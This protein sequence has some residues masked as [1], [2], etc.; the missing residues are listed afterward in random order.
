MIT[1]F[2]ALALWASLYLAVGRGIVIAIDA[3]VAGGLYTRF[4]AKRADI[5]DVGRLVSK[6]FLP[7]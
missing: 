5:S 3:D 1:L 6:F 7:L 2:S 4:L